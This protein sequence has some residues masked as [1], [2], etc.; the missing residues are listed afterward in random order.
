MLAACEAGD[1]KSLLNELMYEMPELL[2][3]L[4]GVRKEREVRE[5]H[6]PITKR[7]IL[8]ITRMIETL[9]T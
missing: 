7:F 3:V 5:A 1:D 2:E 8:K 9:E 4:E 6:P